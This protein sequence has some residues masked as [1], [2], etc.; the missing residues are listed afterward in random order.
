ML[1]RFYLLILFS[2]ALGLALMS[3][4]LPQNIPVDLEQVA[5]Q[6]A[7]I[8]D[9]ET[10]PDSAPYI[11]WEAETPTDTNFPSRNPFAP[12]GLEE[13]LVLS[14]GKWIGT[15]GDR[16]QPLFL[17]YDITVP[18]VGNYYFYTR[19]FWQHGPFRWRWDDQPWTTVGRGF[20]MDESPIRPYVVANWVP[21]GAVPLTAGTH[22]LRV[23][24]TE[25]RGPA[26][27]DCFVLS[28]SPIS[29]RGKLKPDQRYIA[30]IP[31]WAVFDPEP[32][33]FA[34]SP[35][36]LRSLN[37]PFAGAEGWI[38]A[39]GESLIHE[40][41]R[42]PVRFWGVNVGPDVLALDADSLAHMARFL[43]KRGVNIVRF[44][45][46]LN[47]SDRLVLESEKR[48]RLFTLVEA[49]K[50]EGI[51]TSLS[52]YFPLWFK[53]PES[54]GQPPFALLFF[55]PTLQAQYRTLWHDLLTTPNPQTGLS[56]ARDPAVASLELINEDSLMFWT[57]DPNR[58]QPRPREELERQFATWLRDR[59]GSLDA[60]LTAWGGAATSARVASDR[61][62]V[63]SAGE[64]AS[65]P[66]SQRHQDTAAFLTDVQQR[67]FDGTTRYLKEELGYRGLVTASNWITADA[68]RL[69][70]LDKFTNTVG[71]VMDR[72][73]YFTGLHEG[74]R[75]SYALSTGDRYQDRSALLLKRPQWETPRDLN[76]P[77]MDLHYNHKP[78]TISEVNWSMPN[79]F[80]AD[81]PV[82]AAAYGAL[83]DTD[84]FFFFSTNRLEWDSSLGKFSIAS[85][86]VMGQFPATA[87]MYRKGMIQPG[88]AVVNLERRLTD[89]RALRGAPIAA[90]QSLDELRAADVPE[91]QS[92]AATPPE[93]IDP[94]AFFVGQ[95][96]LN[97]D[98]E[99]NQTGVV[100]LNPYHDRERQRIHSS[101]GELTWD[102]DDGLV[103]IDAPQVKG[104]TGF[105]HHAGALRLG[106]LAVDTSVDY[107]SV[108]LVALDDQPLNRS[109]NM[110]LQVMSADENFGWRT[111]AIEGKKTLQ[112][113]GS[114]PL[115]VQEI[116]GQVALRRLDAGQL[117][118]TALDANGVPTNVVGSGDRWELQPSTFYYW[119]TRR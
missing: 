35:I 72:H 53:F 18:E 49:L 82:M 105:L 8:L 69:G 89:L 41:T 104:A 71:D 62:A 98:A 33:T 68:R 84:G 40:R 54:G 77:I 46:P 87:L 86:V 3:R 112:S 116:Q 42:E 56:L 63:M 50:Q 20:L 75:A 39:Q 15:D 64:V 100:N 95:V 9:V 1:R 48:D 36:D 109:Q 102:Y 66:E 11:W 65:R 101:S 47:P 80:R 113:V 60:A 57:F 14:D 118:V 119:I 28:Q 96:N 2:L 17:S 55:E 74:E 4:S 70:P 5:A 7:A 23:E 52:I 115:V 43:A 16:P 38:Q 90:P 110:L 59:Y 58:L 61:V 76:L 45:G 29:A 37:E 97:L 32:D 30:D 25:N 26:A 92:P 13:A 107:G 93:S 83:Q 106:P 6:P 91:G 94:L 114:A 85:P 78:S 117:L 88:D 103:T 111:E 73:G 24:L 67:F 10:L 99:Y 22:T 12:N 19:K 108:L 44:H 79:R 31:S 81:F 21:L 51:Y 34:A 27:F